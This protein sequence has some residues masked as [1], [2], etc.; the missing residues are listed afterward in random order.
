RI[1]E[2]NLTHRLVV[3][4]APIGATRTDRIDMTTSLKPGAA[5]DRHLRIRCCHYNIG[6][7]ARVFYRPALR[8]DLFRKL[9]CVRLGWTPDPN[10]FESPDESQRFNMTAC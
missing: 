3:E 8:T 9:F 2:D 6:S 5:Q 10:F 4:F 7:R 1:D